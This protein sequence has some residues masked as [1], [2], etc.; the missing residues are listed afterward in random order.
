MSPAH[1]IAA[2]ILAKGI[3]EGKARGKL[4]IDDMPHMALVATAGSDSSSPI[5]RTR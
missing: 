1:R 3:S 5:P 4:A 2:R